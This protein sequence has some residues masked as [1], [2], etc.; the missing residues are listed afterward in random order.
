MSA[1]SPLAVLTCIALA[2]AIARPFQLARRIVAWR[3]WDPPACWTQFAVLGLYTVAMALFAAQAW[4]AHG[5]Q[6]VL[7]GPGQDAIP[8]AFGNIA[9]AACFPCG[10]TIAGLIEFLTV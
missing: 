9:L 6:T 10:A 8:A 5:C 7:L 1:V 4:A 2:L 3:D